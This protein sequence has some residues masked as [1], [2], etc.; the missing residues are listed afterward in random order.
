MT[1]TT[2]ARSR[3][4]HSLVQFI[5]TP[6][7]LIL[8]SPRQKQYPKWL[9]ALITAHSRASANRSPSWVY[10]STTPVRFSAGSSRKIKLTGSM[11]RSSH[12]WAISLLGNHLPDAFHR[13]E[14]VS[15]FSSVLWQWDFHGVQQIQSA[16]SLS[17]G[18]QADEV[19]CSTS[20]VR[21]LW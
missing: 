9:W 17:F 13:Q 21:T 5:Y 10:S 3:W 16:K 18:A 19:G 20:W 8:L 4:M 7:I 1:S 14:E 11:F 2:Q 15:C 6:F 12:V